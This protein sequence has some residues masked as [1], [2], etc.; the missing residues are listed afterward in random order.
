MISLVKNEVAIRVSG[1]FPPRKI[2]PR[3]GLRFRLGLDLG[4]NCPRTRNQ[5]SNLLERIA[6]LRFDMR[7]CTILPTRGI[8]R[9]GS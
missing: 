5:L 4:S 6:D 2:A 8:C 7:N 3:I 1:Q 9:E